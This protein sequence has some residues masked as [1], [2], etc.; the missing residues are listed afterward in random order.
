MTSAWKNGSNELVDR[1]PTMLAPL[2]KRILSFRPTDTMCLVSSGLT[3]AEI[4]SNFSGGTTWVRGKIGNGDNIDVIMKSHQ[5]R[6]W[7]HSCLRKCC[8]SANNAGMRGS[9]CS[10]PHPARSR[11]PCRPRPRGNWTGDRRIDAQTEGLCH[12]LVRS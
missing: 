4:V 2:L 5:L 8:P 9:S 12:I 11:G 10:P 6:C 3:L 1:D 7:M